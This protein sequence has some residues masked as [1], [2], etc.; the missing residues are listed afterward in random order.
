MTDRCVN[1]GWESF[2]GFCSDG[3]SR[4]SGGGIGLAWQHDD[5]LSL[6]SPHH[7]LGR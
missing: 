5:V 6:L 4:L 3:R 2:F 7:W 1:V